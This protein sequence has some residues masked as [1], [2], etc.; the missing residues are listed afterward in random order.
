MSDAAADARRR[1]DERRIRWVLRLGGPLIRLLASTW[2][3]REVND[4]PWRAL[5]ARGQAFIFT[6]WHG[7]LLAQTWT[8]RGEGI[9]VMISEHR[10]GEIIARL[11]ES[12]GYRTVRGSTSRGAGRA[13]LGMVREL[14]AGKEFAITPDG[15]RGPAGSVQPGV[16]LASQRA[17]APIV[18][19]RSDVSRAWRLRS[20]DQFLIPKPFATVRI[21]YG[22][23][24]VAADTDEAAAAEVARR[25]GPALP[26]PDARP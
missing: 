14:E 24:F 17:G 12:W 1:R 25:L 15:P 21:T 22:D 11:V 6:L 4:A 19:M 13:L 23:P 2:R 18:T 5:R 3:V 20:W 10:D 26:A 9:T 7:H 16:L 8:R